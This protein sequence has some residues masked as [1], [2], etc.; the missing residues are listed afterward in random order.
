MIDAPGVNQKR[1]S[2]GDAILRK[3]DRG[4]RQDFQEQFSM[5]RCKG[6][7]SVTYAS[8]NQSP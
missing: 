3:K 4:P 5:P 7:S 8:G 6:P 2:R 1:F